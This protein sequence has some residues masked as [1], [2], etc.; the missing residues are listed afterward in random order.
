MADEEK[1]EE[2]E[3]GEGLTEDLGLDESFFQGPVTNAHRMLFAKLRRMVGKD[4][5]ERQ[6]Q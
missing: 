1:N 3:L 4:Y 2:K 6:D 5:E